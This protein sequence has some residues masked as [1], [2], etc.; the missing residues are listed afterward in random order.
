MM[1]DGKSHYELIGGEEG[2]VKLVDQFYDLMDQ[3]EEAQEIRA[4]HASSLK[5]SRHKLVLFLTGW[6]GGPPLYVQE[7]GHPMLRARHLPFAIGESARH[8]WML[9]MTR[10]LD[11]TVENEEVREFLKRALDRVAGH[12]RNQE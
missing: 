7:Y 4:M 9:C 6:L 5:V 11:E 1:I 10:A 3:L 8:Q 12:M 2:V